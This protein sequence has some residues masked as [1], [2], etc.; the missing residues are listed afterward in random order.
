MSVKYRPLTGDIESKT[1]MKRKI[2]SMK[3]TKSDD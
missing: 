2:S 3:N 1:A